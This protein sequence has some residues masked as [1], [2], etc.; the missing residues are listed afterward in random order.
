MKLL[1][2]AVIAAL[3]GVAAWADPFDPAYQAQ[4]LKRPLSSADAS[5]CSKWNGQQHDACQVTRNYLVD[6]GAGYKSQ[7]GY[8][9]LADGGYTKSDAELNTLADHLP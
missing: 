8:P 2:A 5:F 4:L 6:L 1:L 7:H 9:P 3:A